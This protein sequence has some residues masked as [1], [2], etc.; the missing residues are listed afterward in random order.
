MKRWLP[1][2][3]L[4]LALFIVWLLL[5]QSMDSSTLLLAAILAIAVPLLTRSLR[6]ATVRMQ[7]PG[8]ALMLVGRV[9]VDLS[10]SAWTVARMLLTRRTADIHSAFV[11]VPLQMRDPNGLAVLAMILCLTPG[12]AWA[13]LSFDSSVL[14][15]HVFD[16]DDEAA[17]IAQVQQRYERPLMEIFES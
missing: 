17:F 4:S 2:P 11:K 3:P 15:I 8:V 12:T 13:E 16:V 5:N 6:P 1:S 9:M 10:V 7:R 14:L